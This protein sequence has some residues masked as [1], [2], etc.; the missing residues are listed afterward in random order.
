MEWNGS[1]RL[2]IALPNLWNIYS[3]IYR[4][5]V[6]C[7]CIKNT[8]F[9]RL[10]LFAPFKKLITVNHVTTPQYFLVFLVISNGILYSFSLRCFGA[11]SSC[12]EVNMTTSFFHSVHSLWIFCILILWLYSCFLF[13]GIS[14]HSFT[15]TFLGH[16]IKVS[17]PNSH[18]SMTTFEFFWNDRMSI[19]IC[20]QT[21]VVTIFLR[22][23]SEKGCAIY[24]SQLLPKLIT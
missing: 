17:F 21:D 24:P 7:T 4:F 18:K 5:L 23:I 9:S 14:A 22:F 16:F 13:F 3:W 6:S 15:L 12:Y 1:L 11:M 8:F 19:Y 20:S 2:T 10:C